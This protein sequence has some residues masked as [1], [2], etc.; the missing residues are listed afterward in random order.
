MYI[1]YIFTMKSEK[2]KLLP[3]YRRT[4][5]Q[6]FFPPHH[7]GAESWA[8]AYFT[9]TSFSRNEVDTHALYT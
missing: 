5:L 9:Y 3:Q 1:Y 7:E 8:R 2:L 6:L 4:H